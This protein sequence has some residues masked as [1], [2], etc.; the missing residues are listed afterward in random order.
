MSNTKV[1]TDEELEAALNDESQP[2]ITSQPVP[3]R[4]LTKPKYRANPSVKVFRDFQ[5]K[6][7]LVTG[8]NWVEPGIIYYVFDN[9]S[10]TN[11]RQT[12][13]YKRFTEICRLFINIKLVNN[14]QWYGI[15]DEFKQQYLTQ[16]VLD[17]ATDWSRKH[18]GIQKAYRIKKTHSKK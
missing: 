11:K 6:H 12:M 13:N 7:N 15:S 10:F 4:T 8:N 5:D 14:V 9:W 17:K 16:E 18:R 3:L 2:S 1:L